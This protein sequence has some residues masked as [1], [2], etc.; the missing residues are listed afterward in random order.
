M[1]IPC[2]QNDNKLSKEA[3]ELLL[4]NKGFRDDSVYNSKIISFP[5]VF[6]HEMFELGNT[7]IP[8][9]LRKVY[10]MHGIDLRNKELTFNVVISNLCDLWHVSMDALICKWLATEDNV[11][12]LYGSRVSVYKLPLQGLIASDLGPDGILVVTP[13]PL[14]FVK[15][16]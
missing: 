8:L 12:K 9:T 13:L 7:D 15:E 10:N 11:R 3:K 2:K 14:H 1:F 16:E 4:L 5:D 6:M